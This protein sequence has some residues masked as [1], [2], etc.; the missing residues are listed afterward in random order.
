MTDVTH[1]L[2]AI[3]QGDARAAEELLPLVYD[4]LRRLAA[5]KM[6]QE[7]PGQTL[8]ATA[9]VHEAYL[10]LVDVEKAPHW[11][12]RGHFSGAAAEAMR[13]ILVEQ[14][15]R[16]GSLK[17]G[18]KYRRV[19]LS[20]VDPEIHG[21]QLDL[22]ALN[23]ALGKLEAK[24]PR[25]AELVKLRFFAGLTNQQAA[26]AI[27]I[28]SSTADNDWVYAKCWLRLELSRAGGAESPS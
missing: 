11:N 27:G 7:A 28:S 12:S 13:R 3:E 2:S 17:A 8:Q 5:Q 24:D 15:R 21:P 26:E 22:L 23:E 20:D 14:A 25:K 6:A 9:L 1:I 16:K 19:E 18:G 4:E 10:R